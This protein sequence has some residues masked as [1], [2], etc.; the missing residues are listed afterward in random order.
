MLS[1]FAGTR[2]LIS[3]AGSGDIPFGLSTST[4]HV[5]QISVHSALLKG[6]K[7]RTTSL[8]I[9]TGKR[10]AQHTMSSDEVPTLDSILF[11]GSNAVTPLLIWA[12]NSFKVLKVNVIGT[13]HVATVNVASNK[14]TIEKV[15]VHAPRSIN[16]PPHF[17]V[18]YQAASFHWAEV[19]H[20]DPSG[21][22]KRAYSLPEVGGIGAFSASSEDG[23]IYFT[24]NTDFEISLW[25]SISENVIQSW[26]IRPKSHG[27]L[28]DPQGVAHAVSEVRSRKPSGF[29][30]RAALTLPSGDWE[31]IRNGEADWLRSE[32]LAG[33]VAATWVDLTVQPSLAQELAAESHQGVVEA[34]IHRCRRHARDV[35]TYLPGWIE[36]L[37]E[38]IIALFSSGKDSQ[39]DQALKQD[40]FGFSKIV[41]V[42]SGQGRLAALDAGNQ[43]KVLWNIKV[44]NVD[45]G[46][47]W[48]VY[49]MKVEGGIIEIQALNG[50]YLR[51]RSLTGEILQHQPGGLSSS[52]KMWK[53]VIDTS[54]Q[55]MPIS[56]NNDGSVAVPYGT[57][58][59]SGTVVVTKGDDNVARGW[60]FGAD[61]ERRLAWEFVP[62]SR[63]QIQSLLSR[64]PQDPVAS[65]GKALGD[66]NVMY[67]YLSPN[68]LVVTTVEKTSS[69]A[70]IYIL[71]SISG[72]ILHV[73]R[74]LGVDTTRP[75]VA[76]T[77][78][79]W[80]AYT[81]TFNPSLSEGSS[82]PDALKGPH[83]IFSELFD[84]SLANDRGPLGS[85]SNY[86]A[87][88]GP[89]STL[90][91]PYVISQAYLLPG[92]I[93]HLSTTST[94]QS[95]TP[96]SLLAILPHLNG[97]LSIPRTVIDPRRP[98]GRDPTPAEAEEGLFRYSP[99]LDFEPKWMITHGRDVTG[100]TDVISTPSKLES[101]SL[102]FAYGNLDIFGTRVAPIGG[103][104]IL[105]KGFSRV[106]LVLTVVGLA[107]G[108]GALAPMVSRFFPF[109]PLLEVMDPL[110]N[111]KYEC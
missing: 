95:I 81:L 46:H 61:A 4:D 22:V 73:S 66:R 36:A 91:P 96:R 43:G 20:V 44:V 37:P 18:H 71:D 88:R 69:K 28:V 13:K 30:V 93:S 31:L 107:V 52:F 12:D 105:G 99:N 55:E 32:S 111:V 83:L 97:I 10:G 42:A 63:E 101:T 56:I 29:A 25:S 77:A 51:V 2:K 16:T 45:V 82:P 7:I 27:G 33:I 58:F 65:I 47:T 8:D 98:V 80:I 106:Q 41:V 5:Y 87:L 67:K 64:P 79:N 3:V 15:T 11:I 84:S 54:K 48:K 21:T 68:L 34:Y 92:H 86:S 26:P 74:H 90:S 38:R 53:Y 40:S 50:E 110:S 78:E 6:Y 57:K 19:Y 72:E 102:V 103:F 49:D 1:C 59:K 60:T 24:R 62:A 94:L 39:Q 89:D 14:E 35:V 108:T 104:D 9:S 75:I 76:I 109:P 23:K 70:A 100:L 17:L 85:A